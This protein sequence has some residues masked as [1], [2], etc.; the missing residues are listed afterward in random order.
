MRAGS[1]GSARSVRPLLPAA[2]A[3]ALAAFALFAAAC[4]DCE[5]LWA[6]SGAV[7]YDG[8]IFDGGPPLPADGGY[9]D[10]VW[11]D[12]ETCLEVC[13]G[14]AD[15]C[16]LYYPYWPDTDTGALVFLCYEP[17]CL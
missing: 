17:V 5:E 1:P 13:D 8:G 12:E 6:F 15:R 4:S 2:F 10:E 9:P 16:A 14:D 3:L 11:L 7:D